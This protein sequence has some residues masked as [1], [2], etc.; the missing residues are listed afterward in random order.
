MLD[1]RIFDVS[2]IEE[3]I[4]DLVDKP[5]GMRRIRPGQ[6]MPV[7]PNR[8]S[9]VAPSATVEDLL[10]AREQTHGS[11]DDAA[12]LAQSLKRTARTEVGWDKLTDVQRES[13]EMLFTKVARLLSGNPNVKD[14]WDDIAGYAKLVSERIK[15]DRA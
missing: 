14:H 11:F 4:T 6:P 5:G 12:R 13:L 2:Q 1:T 8:P 15:S 3:E 7:L 9:P 10:D